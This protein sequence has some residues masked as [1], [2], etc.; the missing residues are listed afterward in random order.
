MNKQF[1]GIYRAQ[2]ILYTIIENL[3]AYLNKKALNEK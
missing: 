3:I 1:E 2:N